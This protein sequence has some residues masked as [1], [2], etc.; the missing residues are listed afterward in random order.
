VKKL[1]QK[2]KDK[3]DNGRKTIKEL[4]IKQLNHRKPVGIISL[5]GIKAPVEAFELIQ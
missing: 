2:S 1:G 3:Q 5:K 4:L